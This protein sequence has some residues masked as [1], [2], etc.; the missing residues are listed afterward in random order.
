VKRHKPK[1]ERRKS[2]GTSLRFGVGGD[3]D[4]PI[5]RTGEPVVAAVEAET[6]R[7]EDQGVSTGEGQL[8]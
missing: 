5:I 6:P 4:V 3:V 8:L 7:S 2:F 1:G